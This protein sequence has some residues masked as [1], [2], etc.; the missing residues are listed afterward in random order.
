M[1]GRK[2]LRT[3]TL[4]HKRLGRKTKQRWRKARGRDNKIREKR[5]GRARKVQIGYKQPE[6]KRRRIKGK[7]P[8]Y[9]ENIKQ[10]ERIEK[11]ALVIIRKI[12]KK[13][14]M[15][16]EKKIKEIGGEI[17]NKKSGDLSK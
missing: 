5:K 8:I 17:L 13:K 2:F 9:V 15:I 1:K 3:G 10:A 11:G 6:L 14:R 16:I 12:G 4:R 7:I